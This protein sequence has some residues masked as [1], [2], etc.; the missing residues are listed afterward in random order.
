MR[1]SIERANGKTHSK[2]VRHRFRLLE[3]LASQYFSKVIKG[4]LC[5]EF[6]SGAYQEFEGKEAGPH[7]YIKIKN[8]RLLPRMLL[9]GDLGMAESYMAGEWNTT[10]LAELLKLGN[11]NSIAL[12]QVYVKTRL[13]RNLDRI[14][15][16]QRKN[17]PKGSRRN[18]AAHYDL[19][20]N[21]YCKWL[22][23]TM[24]YSS[25]LF[26][27]FNEPLEVSQ[28]RKYLRIA[29]KLELKP[30]QRILEIGCGWGGFTEIAANEFGC[31]VVGLTISNEQAAFA[32]AR[33]KNL[34]LSDKVEIRLQDY[35]DV[36]GEFDKIVSIE[37]FEAVGEEYWQTYL[38]V[39]KRCLKPGGQAALQIITIDNERYA[40]Y[41]NDPEFIQRY[42]F[43]GGMLPS[44]QVLEKA[45][46][47]AKL[48]ITNAFYF[49]KSYA[50][51]LRRWDQAFQ[52]HWPEIKKLG[53]DD[54]FYRMWRYYFCYCEVGFDQ[55]VIDVGQF[56]IE[57]E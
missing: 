13:A 38:G 32:K 29:K 52:A 12:K 6:P 7:A 28:R 53:F 35:R 27:N 10:D 24:S 1:P 23:Q 9:G 56:V 40:S 33:M 25:A 4:R 46:I 49:G 19:G 31:N 55:G 8:L 50:E 21:F 36:E 54:R 11:I 26:E 22:D 42:I 5:V 43:P 14:R 17:T 41:Q 34:Q 48:K 18:I 20:N 2:K 3:L 57:Q 30:G 44:T 45:I 39:L 37:M 51:T 15:H 16:A 47:Q